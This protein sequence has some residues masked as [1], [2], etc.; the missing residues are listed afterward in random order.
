[1]AAVGA[2]VFLAT[3]DGS[4]INVSLPTLV[5]ALSTEFA[6]VQW[7]VLAYLLTVTTSMLSVGRVADILGKKSI[8]MLGFVIF[9]LGSALCGLALSVYWLIA[10]RVVQAVGAAMIMA[11]GA[12][13]VTEAFPPSERGKAMGLIGAIVSI[14]IVV[15]P[16]LG[17]VI[18]G[19]LSWRWIFYVNVPVGIMGAIMVRRNVPDFKPSGRQHFDYWGALTL[20]LSLLSLL[21]GLTFGQQQGFSE[22]VA[23]IMICLWLLLLATFILIEKRVS[24]PMVD[25]QLFSSVLFGINLAT[26]FIT[27]VGLAG[28]MILMPFYLED[29]LGFKITHVGL[30]MGIVPVVLGITSPFSGALSDRV[31]TRPIAVTGLAVLLLGYLAASTLTQYT[32]TFGYLIRMFGLGLG[33]G[34]FVSPNNSAIM[35]TASRHQLGIV[36]GF[37]AITRTLGQT[38]GVAVMGA[39]WAGRT[40]FYAGTSIQ[41]GATSAPAEAQIAA[42]HDTLHAAAALLAVALLLGIWAYVHEAR[43]KG[44]DQDL[45]N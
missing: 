18:I 36:S 3:V 11:L 24:Q 26:G 5:R 16:A 17:G 42:L 10:F 23:K 2:G 45:Q 9:T 32:S 43:N 35:A 7:V 39:I 30:L 44:H 41:G 8:Y 25:L 33:M 12:A 13:I 20:F 37:M 14:G 27:F 28:I 38:V 34:L 22:P 1:M 31:G 6:V 29:I 15:G 19:T 21:L 40:A 4:I